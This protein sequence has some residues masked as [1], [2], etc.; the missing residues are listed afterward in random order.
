MIR[1]YEG[2]YSYSEPIISNWDSNS[3]GVYYCGAILE[4]GNLKP[5]YIGKG[6]GE[7]G[8]RSRLL[9][10]LTKD[11]WFDVTHFGFQRCD[12]VRETE[13]FEMEKIKLYQPKY[14]I[15]GK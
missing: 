8:M 2:H 15:Q 7:G 9:D 5:F 6:T 1:T 12:T 11:N 13:L 4:N 14:N 3:I 10:H